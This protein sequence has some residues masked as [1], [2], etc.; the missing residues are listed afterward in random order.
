MVA[1][2]KPKVDAAAKPKAA[3]K[4]KVKNANH[5]LYFDMITAAIE[6]LKDR[7]GRLLEVTFSFIFRY[8]HCCDRKFER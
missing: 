5:P 7:K 2:A 3:T 8:D 1:A 6:S 4:P